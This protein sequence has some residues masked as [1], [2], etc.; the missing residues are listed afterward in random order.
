MNSYRVL[1]AVMVVVS[2]W[3]ITGGGDGFVEKAKEKIAGVYSVAKS[4]VNRGSPSMKPVYPSGGGVVPNPF[5]PS[6]PSNR[7]KGT[8]TLPVQVTAEIYYKDWKPAGADK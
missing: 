7:L 3:R 4:S 6:M 2:L 5:L 1:G 8:E